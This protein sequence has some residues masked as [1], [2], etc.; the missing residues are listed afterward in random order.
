MTTLKVLEKKLLS[1]VLRYCPNIYLEWLM[2]TNKKGP[3]MGCDSSKI[4]TGHL[5]NRIQSYYCCVNLFDDL[6]LFYHILKPKISSSCSVIS[7][8]YCLVDENLQSHL[9]S[10]SRSYLTSWQLF[11]LFMMSFNTWLNHLVLD[12][13]RILMPFSLSLF[14]PVCCGSLCD[15]IIISL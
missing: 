7:I 4:S 13:P 12:H 8:L 15:G 1:S 3:I 10:H 9:A 2:I 5:W 6:I 11:P 14:C